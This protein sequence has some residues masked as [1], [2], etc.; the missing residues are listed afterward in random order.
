[1]G[2][3][4]DGEDLLKMKTVAGR[5]HTRRSLPSLPSLGWCSL[6]PPT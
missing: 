1:M 3:S 6:V 2:V 4:R 5:V